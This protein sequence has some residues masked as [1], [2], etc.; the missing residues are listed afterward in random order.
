[1]AR[2]FLVFTADKLRKIN[3]QRRA[4]SQPTILDV[5]VLTKDQVMYVPEGQMEG[6]PSSCYNCAFFNYDRS[7]Q[8]IGSKVIVK[9]MV[10]PPKA[11]A[12]AKRI[13]YWP[14]CGQW[15]KGEPN[16]GEEKFIASNSPD[17]VGLGWINAPEPGLDF[18]GANCGGKDGGDDCDH[19]ITIGDDKRIEP[20]AFCR[21]LQSD[22][23]CGAVCAAWKDDDYLSWDRAQNIFREL[24]A[25]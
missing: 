5:P 9:K 25:R 18:S 14:C 20:T 10:Y 6:E 19:Y 4:L 21:V 7:C 16:Y 1:M 24:D 17:V 13:E 2:N 12:D 11:T 22:V 8:L 23:E 15:I 3:A